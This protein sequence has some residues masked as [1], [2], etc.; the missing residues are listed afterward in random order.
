MLR[1]VQHLSFFNYAFEALIV[2]EMRELQLRDKEIIDIKVCVIFSVL[3]MIVDSRIGDFT[4]ASIPLSMADVC[5]FGFDPDRF[6]WD[7]TVL[8]FIFVALMVT[9]Y[10][11]LKFIVKERR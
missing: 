2:N 11:F 4:A 9:A 7:V 5:R 3:L 6:A 10:L 8:A 1:W